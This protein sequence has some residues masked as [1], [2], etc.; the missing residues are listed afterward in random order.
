L[1]SFKIVTL[2][3][4]VNQCESESLAVALREGGWWPA[5]ETWPASLC[6][7]N[8]C[9]VTGKA[10]MQSRQ[11]VRQAVRANPGACVVVTGCYAQT[12]AEVLARIDGV[13]L[14]VGHG[15]KHRVLPLVEAHLAAVGADDG[16]VLLP[17]A[18]SGPPKVHRSDVMHAREFRRISAAPSGRRARPSLKIQD[19]CDAFCTYCIVPYARGRSR[20]MAVDEV[21]ASIQQLHDSGFREV[22]L[23]GIHLGCYGRD[24]S[25]PTDLA[26]LLRRIDD[27]ARIG[28]VRLSSIEPLELTEEIIEL[29]AASGRFCPHFHVPLQ[30]GD[31]RVLAR[32]HRPY[33]REGFAAVVLKIADQMPRATIGAD[34][35]V[36]FPG[37]SEAA[38]QNSLDMVRDLPICYL[39]VFPFSPR[40]GT[41]AAG[42]PD[43]VPVDVI[44]ER[45]RRLRS[46][47][48]AK[49]KAFYNGAL[50]RRVEVLVENERDSETGLLKGVSSEY[51]TVLLEGGDA[52]KN[53][54][55]T[56]AVERV[57]SGRLAFGRR[58]DASPA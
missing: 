32:M 58:A 45:C 1:K 22:V 11:A 43:P 14:I 21:M 28:R 35:L 40:T 48:A 18:G 33:T 34:V 4:R 49:R 41:P 19:G 6:I 57:W 30:S 52:L 29:V 44:K 37:E 13:D 8:T 23:S 26:S 47:G 36:G 31:N 46:L 12:E 53:D 56:V 50:G 3:C 5:P 10:S 9:T 54:F 15:E 51:L 20:S 55:V 7:I 38:F 39:H 27:E 42:Y 2:G 24:L 25:P 16:S 17:E